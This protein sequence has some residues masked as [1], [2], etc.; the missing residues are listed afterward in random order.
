MPTFEQLTLK[1]ASQCATNS[2]MLAP[3]NEHT[4]FFVLFVTTHSPRHF[5]HPSPC[6]GLGTCSNMLCALIIDPFFKPKSNFHFSFKRN[7]SKI[8]FEFHPRMS[9][10]ICGNMSDKNSDTRAELI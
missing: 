3:Y 8:F 2:A 7:V 1:T 9:N 6:E 10:I 4:L 5:P